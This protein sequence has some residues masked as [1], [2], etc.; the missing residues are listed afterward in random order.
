MAINSRN[1]GNDF[2]RW[3]CTLLKGKGW[4]AERASY[5]NK[6]LDNEGKVDIVTNYPANFQLKATEQC[7]Q[8][9]KVLASMDKS[10]TRRI[11]WKRNNKPVL[12]VMELDEYFKV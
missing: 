10:K 8:F 3:F 9:S 12:I 6:K 4:E 2:E 7:P 11:V 1:K 5:V